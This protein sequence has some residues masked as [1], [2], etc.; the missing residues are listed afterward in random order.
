MSK[1]GATKLAVYQFIYNRLANGLTSPTVR[2]ICAELHLKSTSTAKHHIDNLRDEGYITY[3]D[4]LQRT[5][6]LTGKTP[7]GV[8]FKAPKANE[9]TD[10]TLSVPLIGKVA[11]G[12][13]L[14]SFE[15][16]TAVYALPKE[17]LRGADPA[18][19]FMLT[20]DS[21]SMADIGMLIGDM[22]I[23]TRS[24]GFKDGDIVVVSVNNQPATVKRIFREGVRMVRLQAENGSMP[25]VVVPNV[26]ANVIGR[27][28][29]L[30][31]S[32]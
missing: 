25:P 29:G 27:V 13:P 11:A 10:S 16:M 22:I 19:T 31:R 18:E 28:I 6:R 14:Y 5:I 24:F 7:E 20:V 12:K 23:V 3:D 2:E 1:R 17:I 21:E 9:D 8:K 15:D 30:I 26:Q 4:K 32:Y